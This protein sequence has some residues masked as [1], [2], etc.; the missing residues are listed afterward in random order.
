[1]LA[2]TPRPRASYILSCEPCTVKAFD[3]KMGCRK[4]KLSEQPILYLIPFKNPGIRST[5]PFKN[6][7]RFKPQCNFDGCV[8]CRV[9]SVSEVAT[10]FEAKIMPYCSGSGFGGAGAAHCLPD[11]RNGS[12]T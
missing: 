4:S 7:I 9:R 3:E 12:G 5:I 2:A 11:G 1:M 8:F 10:D 6:F